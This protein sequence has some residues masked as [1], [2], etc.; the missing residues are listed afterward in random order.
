MIF[1]QWICEIIIFTAK[2]HKNS[3][4]HSYNFITH[5]IIRKFD[6]NNYERIVCAQARIK[7]RSKR[8]YI[9]SPGTKIIPST[10]QCS[11]VV[12]RTFAKVHRRDQLLSLLNLSL[13]LHPSWIPPRQKNS[14]HPTPFIVP[15]W[16]YCSFFVLFLSLSFFF[17]LFLFLIHDDRREKLERRTHFCW[18]HWPGPTDIILPPELYRHKNVMKRLRTGR[19][20]QMAR[21]IKENGNNGQRTAGQANI[22]VFLGTIRVAVHPIPYV[23]RIRLLFSPAMTRVNSHRII[24]PNFVRKFFPSLYVFSGFFCLSFSFLSLFSRDVSAAIVWITLKAEWI[25]ECSNIQI[26]LNIQVIKGIFTDTLT[27]IIL[28]IRIE[29]KDVNMWP[30]TRINYDN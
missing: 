10:K 17:L 14:T 24:L 22:F 7:T 6:L 1:G 29:C 11:Q 21:K 13:H 16:I 23:P 19:G 5:I 26:L 9:E 20:R 8:D 12:I 30:Y 15:S 27:L 2:I 18:C 4:D 25:I 3:Y 28:A